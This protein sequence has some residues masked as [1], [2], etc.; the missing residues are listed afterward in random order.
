MHAEACLFEGP[1]Q[2]VVPAMTLT[3]REG[4]VV[5]LVARAARSADSPPPPASEASGSGEIRGGT[6]RFAGATGRFNLNAT[7]HGALLPG[8]GV[9]TL[10]DI[11]LCGYIL[12][13]SA[14]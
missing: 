13:P 7:S 14:R 3:D 2:T 4:D 1:P 12:L 6:G 10:R 8:T 9:A 11:D 5:N